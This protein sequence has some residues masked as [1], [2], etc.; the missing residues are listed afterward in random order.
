MANDDELMGDEEMA[1]LKSGAGESGDTA[2]SGPDPID[3]LDRI[4]DVQVQVCAELGRRKVRIAE[5]LALTPGA[6]VEFPKS[7]D[8]P[9]DIRVNDRLIAR[10]E[11]VVIGERYGVRVTEVVSPNERLQ[12]S[13]V[14][15]ETAA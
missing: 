4:L 6:V 2:L 8:E 13:G 10:G 11:A 3:E 15:K 7:A 14:I 5:V 9:L 12:S 1:L